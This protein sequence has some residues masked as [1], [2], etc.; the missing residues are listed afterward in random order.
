M[1]TTSDETNEI[2]LEGTNTNVQLILDVSGSMGW[3]IDDGQGGTTTGM[4]IMQEAVTEMLDKYDNLGNVKVN[5]VTF[6]TNA[7]NISNG[8]VDVAAAKNLVDNLSADGNTNYDDALEVTTNTYGLAGS[9]V[10]ANNVSYFLTDGEPTANNN[11]TNGIQPAEETTWIN[12]LE[13]NDVNSFAYGMGTGASQTNMDPVA[14]DA[15]TDTNTNAVVVANVS[16]LPPVLRDSVMDASNGN[17]VGSGGL[18]SIGFGADGGNLQSIQLDGTTYTYDADE[19]TVVAS[20]G[21]DRGSYDTATLE[22]TIETLK[23][24]KFVMNMDSGD[25]AYTASGDQTDREEETIYYTVVD[26]DGDESS[27]TL[28]IGINPPADPTI[29]APEESRV[30]EEGLTDGIADAA[31][32]T[33]TTDAVVSTGQFTITDP[34]SSTAPIVTL[35]TPTGSYTSNGVNINWSNDGH[36]LIGSAA[37]NE[38][39]KVVIDDTGAYTTTLSGAIDHTDTT[40]EDELNLAVDV[41][42]DDGTGRTA[43]S[44]LNVI[45]EDDAPITSDVTDE[46]ILPTVDSNVQLILDFSGSMNDSIDDG[47]GTNT[48]TTGL[49]I[50][51]EAVS[52]MLDKYNNLGDV[53]VHIVTFSASATTYANGSSETWLSVADAKAYVNGLELSDMSG[54]TNYDAAL[55]EAEGTYDDAGKIADAQNVSYF[56]TDGEPTANDNGTNGIQAD[57]ELIWT[58]FLEANDINSF[59]YGMGDGASQINMNPVA[60]D[61]TVPENTYAVVVSNVSEL[62]P[63]LRDSV[64]DATGGSI[65][66]GGLGDSIGFGA[67]GGDIQT[68]ILDGST[69]TYYAETNEVLVTAGT[70]NS[71]Y[72]NTTY[73]LSIETGLDGKF[74]INVDNGDYNYTASGEQTEREEERIDYTVVDADGD[75]SG[76]TLIIGIN[77]P[78]TPYITETDTSVVQ[79]EAQSIGYA[80]D[81]DGT[82][83]NISGTATHG[84]ISLGADD[85]IVYTPNNATYTGTDTV[86]VTVEDNEGNT[87]TRDIDVTILS[88]ADNA[89]APDLE[90]SIDTV[91][92]IISE[93]IISQ[94]FNSNIDDWDGTGE[95]RDTNTNELRIDGNGD[96]ATNNVT[97]DFGGSNAGKTVTIEFTTDIRTDRWDNNDDDMQIT[98]GGT[99]YTRTLESDLDNNANHSF[100]GVLNGSGILEIEILNSSDDNNE[101]LW[102]D[103]F[104]VILPEQYK[105]TIDLIPTL[106]DQDDG[107]ETLKDLILKDLPSSVSRV[108]YSNGDPVSNANGVYTIATSAIAS[109]TAVTVYIYSDDILTD[110][111]K[112]AIHSRVTSEEPGGDTATVEVHDGGTAQVVDGIIVGLYYETSSGLTGYTDADGYF[113]YLED[114]SVTFKIG[115][116]AVGSIE[117]GEVEDG[118]VFLQDIADVERTDV[119][120]EYVEN[121]AV[122]LQSLD[123]D[124]GDNIVITEEM[125]EAFADEEFDLA[126]ISEEDLAAVIEENGYDAVSEDDAMEHVGDMLVEYTSL[127]ESDLDERTA[128]DADDEEEEE[129]TMAPDDEGDDSID[130]SALD[131]SADETEAEE[132]DT[133]D[134][135]SEET[136]DGADETAGDDSEPEEAA[137]AAEEGDEDLDDILPGENPE[138]SAAAESS[139]E[140]APAEPVEAS[141]PDPTVTVTVEEQVPVEAV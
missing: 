124:S 34:S 1:P 107:D 127:E 2:T 24:G 118:K 140:S 38:I 16:E 90:M 115:N 44:T 8:W 3:N 99:V 58:T 122:L 111:E 23:D 20:V 82:I 64:I 116:I 136:E 46:I 63:V 29:S 43:S 100:T 66:S 70:N 78:G 135:V 33:D 130:M 15:T 121:M 21:T 71:T 10:D 17:I 32:N 14:Y 103:D 67:D 48:D 47:T 35:G 139:S 114:D 26:G 37:G 76:S 73:E 84:A 131:E 132:N 79:G 41:T 56:L 133:R 98:A 25:Y 4:A 110:T 11:G 49:Y 72:D 106:N 75:T 112:E 40:I 22:L 97:Y 108:E 50:M 126:T 92:L 77:P 128:D 94:D 87:S 12:F 54:N 119:N 86:T 101:D 13:T 19:N 65:V 52:E 59:A 85:T 18:N 61:G 69:Y 80:T 60:Y 117:M 28:T 134:E 141:A 31:G 113:D 88:D 53:K 89:D 36:T 91:P 137:P 104:T 45:I 68:V 83:L 51:Q 102:I 39:I 57:E 95:S 6:S 138:P 129:S 109:G 9:L 7:Q 125:H 123:S 93:V 27:S 5:I 42:V 96:T 120:D 55:T 62:P 105:Y 74:V 30:S 81:D